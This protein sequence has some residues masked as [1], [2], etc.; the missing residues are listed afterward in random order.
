[1]P[2]ITLAIEIGA[3]EEVVFDLFRSVD[4][5]VQSTEGT[6]ER[7]VAGVTSGLLGL[8]DEVSW[9]AVHFGIR[10]RLTSRITAFDRPHSFRDSMV[11]GAFLRFD[12]EHVFTPTK[13]GTLV[14]DRF[15][16]ETP[17]GPLGWM[18]EH[19]FLTSYMRRFLERRMLAIKTIAESGEPVPFARW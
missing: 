19:L 16:F 5:H 1:M 18:A 15:D 9:E 17:F 8:G 13:T 12:H 2:V 7:A 10:Q 11:S 14:S 3:P 4:L 6:R